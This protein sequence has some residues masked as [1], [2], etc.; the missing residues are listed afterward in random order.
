MPGPRNTRRKKRAQQQK[1]K[2]Q[3]Q[4]ATAQHEPATPVPPP[5]ILSANAKPKHAEMQTATL[6]Y[7]PLPSKPL[8]YVYPAPS[9]VL[10]PSTTTNR[11]SDAS[12]PLGEEAVGKPA[13]AASIPQDAPPP[14]TCPHLLVLCIYK[15]T[16]VPC[17]LQPTPSPRT[18]QLTCLPNHPPP[19]PSRRACNSPT[20]P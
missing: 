20:S 9:S 13:E 7:K 4:P 18:L 10:R 11:A 8:R 6:A 2:R 14:G 15:L 1:D 17:T 12:K 3:H 5:S 16:C 19:M